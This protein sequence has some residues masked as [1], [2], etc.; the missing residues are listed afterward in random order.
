VDSGTGIDPV[1]VP[2]LF[3][4]FFTTKGVG[5][6]SGIGLSVVHGVTHTYD[7]HLYITS[8]PGAGT[9]ISLYF[10]PVAAPVMPADLSEQTS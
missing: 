8:E 5:A 7:G 10:Q 3:E 4:P 6:G 1:I 2:K 9:T